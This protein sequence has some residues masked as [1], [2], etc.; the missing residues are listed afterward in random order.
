VSDEL[1]GA[2]RSFVDAARVA[3]LGTVTA[4]GEP[5]VVPVC[6]VLDLDRIVFSSSYDRK[7]ANIRDNP[8]VCVAFDE[9]SEDRV[10]GLRQVIVF[11][12]AYLVESGPEWERDRNLLSE[13][14]PQYPVTS[15]MELDETVMV[16]IRPIRVSSSG[17]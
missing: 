5:H 15:P 7:V 12:T 4:D 9:C 11:G 3:H 6:P 8:A 10:N 16:E 17:L 13:K 14:Y 1:A 2:A